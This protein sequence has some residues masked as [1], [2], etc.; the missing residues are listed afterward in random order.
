MQ[1]P[2]FK[3]PTV[4]IQIQLQQTIDIVSFALQAAENI[5]IES[6]IISGSTFQLSPASNKTMNVED[7]RAVF[8][9]WVLGNGLRD[10]VDAIGPSLEW[11]RKI[12][13]LWTRQGKVS[14][15]EDGNVRL[16]ARISGTEWN[17][18]LIKEGKDFEY[19]S[20]RS[21]LDILNKNYN[22]KIPE[23]AES[24]LSISSVRNCLTHRR[25]IVGLD[26]VKFKKMDKLVV[27]WRKMHLTSVED[28]GQRILELPAKVKAGEKISIGY[29]DVSKEFSVGERIQITSQEFIQIAT[30][31]LLF[32]VQIQESIHSLQQSRKQE[33]TS[34]PPR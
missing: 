19:L 16:N 6:L 29:S 24:I 13:F 9:S 21:K 11:A 28:S 32:A 15:N 31:F 26:D 2:E 20:F 1:K 4:E 10:F 22:F 23:L 25:G 14:L 18:Q 30:T 12:C 8:R 7:T 3:D 17:E 5:H 34:P 27:H 33:L